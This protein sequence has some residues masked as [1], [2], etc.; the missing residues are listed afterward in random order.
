MVSSILPSASQKENMERKETRRSILQIARHIRE[1]KGGKKRNT[2]NCLAGD[3]VRLKL[4]IA[5]QD[6][7][8]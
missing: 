7:K 3:D 2:K 5:L 6:R 1:N 4:Q 8:R